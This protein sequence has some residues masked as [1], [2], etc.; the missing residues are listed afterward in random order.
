MSI[1]VPPGRR[2][3]L[4]AALGNF[5]STDASPHP[6]LCQDADEVTHSGIPAFD[7]EQ[8]LIELPGMPA[9][10]IWAF[11]C[12]VRGCSCRVAIVLSTPG[13]RETLLERGQPVAVAWLG[14][15]PYGQAAQDLKGV[16]A[17][18]VDL[19]TRDLFPPVGDAPLDAGTHPGV[20]AIVDRLDD[21]VLDAIARVW[22]LGKGDEPPPD[23]GAGGAKIEVEGWRPGDL[24]VWDL[25]RPSL[26]DDFYVLGDHVY[27][28]VELYCVEPDC[29]C[30]E[31]IV[32]FGPVVPRG[33]PHPGHVEFDGADATLHPDHERH[34]AR[35]T[36]LWT[37]YGRRHANHRERFARRSAI[38]HDLAGRI[39][40][41]PPKPKV[42]RN[43]PCP[44]G[45]GR[46]HKQC[47][48]A[49]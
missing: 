30:G 15:R 27:E 32:D 46:K 35:L 43:A 17:F 49:A 47:C 31:L 23:P 22:H 42:G 18:A 16:T 14:H 38:M 19:D 29:D 25:A 45:S 26:R 34:R 28:A 4:G 33:A 20:K 7:V 1:P 13:D 6:V 44:C 3:S 41:A 36:E 12:P 37:A 48:G 5:E 24:V 9:G 11:T 8:G 21:D 2:R 40:A 39:V 10:W